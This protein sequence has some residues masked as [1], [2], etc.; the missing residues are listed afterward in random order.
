MKK[1]R[2]FFHLSADN[3]LL[4]VST[5]LLLVAVRLGL[6]LLPFQ[7]LCHSLTIISEVKLPL[8]T[9]DS[10]DQKNIVWAVEIASY[11]ML[12]DVK[13][14]ARALTTQ[15]LLE[16]HGY[17]S[18][19]RIGIAKGDKGQFEA[20]AWVESQGEIAIGNIVEL[21]RYTP[22]PPITLEQIKI[23]G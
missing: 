22:L 16:R 18:E 8:Q 3:R 23:F 11:Y 13:C 12:G 2:E 7:R 6:W 15:A 9:I 10:P 4:L 14:L 21:S 19:L 17:P 1:L 20:H 5:W